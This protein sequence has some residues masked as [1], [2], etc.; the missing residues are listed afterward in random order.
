MRKLNKKLQYYS[1]TIYSQFNFFLEKKI[2]NFQGKKKFLE[3][4]FLS[5]HFDRALLLVGLVAIFKTSFF[6][7]NPSFFFFG[8][9][10]IRNLEKNK[11]K[12]FTR[13]VGGWVT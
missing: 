11:N 4:I 2:A 10:N 1:V 6:L 13:Y 3:I 8:Y 5:P 9:Y 7:R 12:K